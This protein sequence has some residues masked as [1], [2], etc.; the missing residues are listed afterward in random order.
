[1]RCYNQL[2]R[3]SLRAAERV[4]TVCGAFARDVQATGVPAERIIVQHN[5]VKPFQP[6][7]PAVRDALRATFPSGAP[8]LLVV[9]RLSHEKGHIDLLDA[10]DMLRRNTSQPFHAVFVGDGPEQ[11]KV[12]AA[13]A[14][15]GLESYVTMAGLQHDVRPYYGIATLVVMP[16]HSEGSPNVLLEA[17]AAGVPVVA[18]RVGGVPEIANDGETAL[19]VESRKPPAMAAALQR[20]LEDEALRTRLA[21]NAKTLA[22]Q[23]YSPDAYRRSLVGIYEKVLAE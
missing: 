6:A 16:S 21:C 19:L 4:V 1:M 7:A 12:E 20:M 23:K 3:W 22:G 18:T 8:I 9:G 13:R 17:M 5:S 2:D 11:R 14:R 15:L 10:L